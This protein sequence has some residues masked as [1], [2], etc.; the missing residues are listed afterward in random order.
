VPGAGPPQGA[1]R[2]LVL[3]AIGVAAGFFSAL[4]GVGGGILIVPL[5]IALLG[6]DAHSS[7]ATSLAAIIFIAAF[8]AAIYAWRGHLELREALLVGLPA[9]A[10][11]LIGLAIKE[12][13]SSRALTLAFAVVLAAVAVR[14][15]LS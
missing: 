6:Y 9:V 2:W 11:L 5:L 10:G 3:G 4:F 14:L 13:L 15:A 12:R 7:T 1:A 8:G